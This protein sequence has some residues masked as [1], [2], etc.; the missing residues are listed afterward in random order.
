MT[1]LTNNQLTLPTETKQHSEDT[2]SMFYQ[3]MFPRPTTVPPN[4]FQRT[5]SLSADKINNN[6]F[7]HW[8]QTSG[9]DLNSVDTWGNSALFL[10]CKLG[11]TEMVDLLT[12]QSGI[13][14][15][16]AQQ[17]GCT[18]GCTP[19]FMACA[20]GNIDVVKRLLLT[21]GV[22]LNKGCVLGSSPLGVARAMGRQ[23]VVELLSLHFQQ[24]PSGG[25]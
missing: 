1:S 7:D 18:Q 5:I 21:P 14:V 25:K 23:N 20:N 19:F 11:H 16:K 22:D 24:R 12:R 6:P 3:S 8:E 17:M 15:N 4:H 10:A 9:T 2:S 13:E